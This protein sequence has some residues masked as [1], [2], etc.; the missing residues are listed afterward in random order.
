MTWKELKDKLEALSEEHLNQQVSFFSHENGD[1]WWFSL[2]IADERLG[3]PK[4]YGG[5][6]EKG[7]PYLDFVIQ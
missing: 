3:D 1:V 5:T 7:E 6:I 2:Y 4:G